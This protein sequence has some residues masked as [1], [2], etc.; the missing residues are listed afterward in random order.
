MS[1]NK[2]KGFRK[3][4][5]SLAEEIDSYEYETTIKS[6]RDTYPHL[7]PKEK[8]MFEQKFTKPRNHSQQKY[9]QELQ[10]STN[11]IIIVTGPAGTGKT[12]FGTEYAI[13]EF[14]CG[15]YDK[16][17]FTR[18]TVSVEEDLGYLPGTMEEK[19]APWIRPIYDILY[20][21]I[22]PQEVTKLI[23]D[24]IIEIC[25]LG[26]MRGRT[27]KHC[28]I[29]AD[30]MQNAS[31]AQLKL[32]LTRIGDDC[33]LIITGDLEQIDRRQHLEINGLEDFLTKYKGIRSNSISS[34]EFDSKDVERS[35]IVKEVL[36]IYKS[37]IIPTTYLHEDHDHKETEISTIQDI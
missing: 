23:E 6:Y 3:Y 5:K 27:F 25:P 7:S 18:P 31:P 10:K 29:I 26:F 9:V 16:L 24:K 8:I 20:Q 19:M 11:K 4:N 14:L 28:W 33:R 1:K 30:E 12:L 35:E 36:H 34:I 13:K 17:I 15:Y 32:L 22:S 2:K 37:E 21:F